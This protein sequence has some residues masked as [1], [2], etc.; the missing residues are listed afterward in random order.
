MVRNTLNIQGTIVHYHPQFAIFLL[1]NQDRVSKSSQRFNPS[2][3][4]ISINVIPNS[5]FL[6][7]R[8]MKLAKMWS[9]RG[10][11]HQ[12]NPMH[13]LANKWYTLRFSKYI[14]KPF[15]NAEK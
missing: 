4:M 15:F 14:T 12:V 3:C 11:I 8:Y 7:L 9:R 5:L 2:L 10:F 13:Y 1:N 6:C